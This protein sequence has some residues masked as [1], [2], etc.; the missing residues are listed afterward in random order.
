MQDNEERLK[1]VEDRE[2]QINRKRQ[3]ITEIIDSFKEDISKQEVSYNIAICCFSF[4]QLSTR[5][6]WAY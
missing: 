3:E 1:A 4:I 6:P 2:Q 5:L